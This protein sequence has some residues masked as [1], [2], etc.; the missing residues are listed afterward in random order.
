MA[1]MGKEPKNEWIYA[2]VCLIHFAA[3]LKL[4]ENIVNQP[5]SNKK[6]FKKQDYLYNY[7]YTQTN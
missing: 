1:C 4:T 2:H 6:L 3:H 7:L 5:T